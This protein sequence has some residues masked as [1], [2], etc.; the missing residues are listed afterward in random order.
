V[1]FA[2]LVHHRKTRSIIAETGLAAFLFL[3]DP[4]GIATQKSYAF[5]NSVEALTQYDYRSNAA[6]KLAVVLIDQATLS[7]WKV[8]WPVTY[9]KVTDL[10]HALACA[11]VSGVFFDFTTSKEFNLATGQEILEATIA[12]SSNTGPDCSDGQRPQKIKVFF[13]KIDEVDTA[14]NRELDQASLLFRVDAGPDANFYSAGKPQ[15][16]NQPLKLNEV[17]AAFGIVRSLDL[18]NSGKDNDSGAL[19]APADSR[20]RCW[21]SPLRLTWSGFV[22]PEQARVSRIDGCRGKVDWFTI[23]SGISGLTSAGRYETCPPILTLRADDLYRDKYY[24]DLNGDPASL[25]AGRFV[26]VGVNLSGLNDKVFSPIHGYLPGVYKHAMATDNLITYGANYPT[27]P[28]PW[29]LGLIAILIYGIIE[30][31][32]ELSVGATTKRRNASLVSIICA[33]SFTTV[34]F[35]CKWPPSVILAVFTYYAGSMLFFELRGAAADKSDKPS[36]RRNGK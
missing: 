20:P 33:V 27:V 4:L 17:T 7:N 12:D 22:N 31:T 16:P 30:T 34:V 18:I 36:I 6:E 24:I 11:K 2:D 10:V 21:K 19:C 5:N 29:L 8:D 28:S 25:L 23:F 9:E 35:F 14:F 1:K 13:A 32:K 26:F 15:F 3:S